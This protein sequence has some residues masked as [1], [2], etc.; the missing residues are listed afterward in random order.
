MH[1]PNKIVFYL[2]FILLIPFGAFGQGNEIDSLKNELKGHSPMDTIRAGLLIELANKLTYFDPNEA[3]PLMEE[4]ISISKKTDWTLGEALSH[5]QMGNL[6]YVLG[7]N[8]K[9]LD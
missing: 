4:A 6:H 7:D 1:Q 3:I 9:A 5:R 8:I 2:L